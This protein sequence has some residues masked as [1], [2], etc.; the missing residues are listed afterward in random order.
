MLI[1]FNKVY[2]RDIDLY[3]INNFCNDS[4]FLELF[5]SKINKKNYRVYSAESSLEDIDGESDITIVLEN[6]EKK[7]GLLIE[8]KIDARAMYNQSRR[9]I[10]RGEKGVREGKYDEF[11]TFIIAPQSY[12]ETNSEAQKYQCK[13]SY[14]ELRD[15]VTDEYG[16]ALFEKALE[17]KKKG[18]EPIVDV[19]T[20]RF[21]NSYYE[22]V[23]NHYPDI[24]LYKV[25][26]PRGSKGGWPHV[27]LP[28]KRAYIM[29]KSDRG[30]VDL[31]FN[32]L[33]EYYSGFYNYMKP[34]L[35]TGMSIHRTGK[36]MAV[37]MMVPF[38]DFHEEFEKYID[39]ESDTD[40]MRKNMESILVLQGF[41]Y[42]LNVNEVYEKVMRK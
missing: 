27:I 9:Y 42:G 28:D 18:Y 33:G 35:E 5:Q 14:E 26:G 16:K 10:K 2:E 30:Y 34:R 15:A 4:A 21:W 31:T 22:Y 38:V 37:R 25:K 11:Y 20:T 8:D 19:R 3:V 40:D 1:N 23:D 12:L 24:K 32:S 36:S 13:I 29:H 41:F 7:I 39:A 17:I 6:E